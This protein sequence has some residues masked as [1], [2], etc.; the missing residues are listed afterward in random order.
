MTT[1]TTI[2]TL[3]R[4]DLKDEDSANYRWVDAEIDRAV[5]KA[6]LE[7]SEYCPLQVRSTLATVDSDN[8]VDISTLTDRIDILRVEHPVIGQPYQSHRF[9]VWADVL[10]FLDGYYG[11][12]GN[13]YVYW[14]KKHSI[15]AS[16]ST[17][18]AAHEHIIALGAAAFAISS[19]AE[20]SVNTANTGGRTVNKDYSFWAKATFTQFYAALD[21]IK[22]YNPKKLKTGGLVPEE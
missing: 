15:G 11:D 19:Q 9:S 1:I 20:Y 21:R 17:V 5:D 2:R 3:V 10:T 6:V 13:C 8:T 22:S 12:A 18:P 14:L 16:S 4:R 7:Y